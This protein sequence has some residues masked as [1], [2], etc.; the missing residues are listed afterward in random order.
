KSMRIK[1]RKTVI[2]IS[3]FVLLAAVLAGILYSFSGNTAPDPAQM[4]EEDAVKFVAT[5]KFASLPVEEKQK[6]MQKM[7]EKNPDRRGPPAA[8]NKLTDSERKAVHANMLQVMQKGMAERA[9][10]FCAMSQE[11]KN[12]FL[13]KMIED[14]NKRRQEMEQ[15]RAA[16]A[17]NPNANNNHRPPGGGGGAFM[18]GMLENTSAT[19]RAQIHEMMKAMHERRAAQSKK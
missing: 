15:R 7:R 12:A 17:N 18:Q 9:K 3:V 4:G 11:E 14:M 10:Q 5:K 8:F 19:S 2:V 13:D 6:Y 16:D 1:N